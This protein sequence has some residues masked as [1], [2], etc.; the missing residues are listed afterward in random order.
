MGAF[1][2]GCATG[3]LAQVR[4]RQVRQCDA[5]GFAK[6]ESFYASGLRGLRMC[7][8]VA[9][10]FPERMGAGAVERA[11]LESVCTS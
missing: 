1:G 9:H 4:Q 6:V 7:L 2:K 10:S 3:Y 8:R 11:R 5:M